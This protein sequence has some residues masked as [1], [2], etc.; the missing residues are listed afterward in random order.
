M[1]DTRELNKFLYRIGI[2]KRMNLA[3]VFNHND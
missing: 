3:I 2:M 1:I